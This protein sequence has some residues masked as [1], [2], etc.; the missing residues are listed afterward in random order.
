MAI[1]MNSF[2]RDLLQFEILPRLQF[3]EIFF[4]ASRV[5]RTWYECVHDS[6]FWTYLDL[7][8]LCQHHKDL[9][10]HSI[11]FTRFLYKYCHRLQV[12]IGF[13][14]LY[15]YLPDFHFNNLVALDIVVDHGDSTLWDI[16]ETQIPP[17][18][19]LWIRI[20]DS[21]HV[22]GKTLMPHRFTMRHLAL[23]HDTSNIIDTIGSLQLQSLMYVFKHAPL[24]SLR[25]NLLEFTK[26]T[27]RWYAIINELLPQLEIFWLEYS[28]LFSPELLGSL[29][30]FGSNLRV[31]YL[32][33]LEVPPIHVYAL[34]D[35]LGCQLP[36]LL[37]VVAPCLCLVHVKAFQKIIRFH[38]ARLQF[39][40]CN[41]GSY[42][43]DVVRYLFHSETLHG[44][45]LGP[46]DS[47]HHY[48]TTITLWEERRVIHRHWK[49][50]MLLKMNREPF[51][52]IE[53]DFDHRLYYDCF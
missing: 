10:M 21:T 19:L 8:D 52:R 39:M 7:N 20:L 43:D 9:L 13:R 51:V 5:C 47:D 3:G 25:I 53:C 48:I 38:Q 14:S 29:T 41:D 34:Y 42:G 30:S 17:L 44:I 50:R 46:D 35:L 12:V 26:D 27:F 31:L 37:I 11:S 6:R 23:G 1:Q 16:L 2:P 22:L 36:Q 33:A 32:S 40:G 18:K 15:F 49:F 28:V 4:C 45:G 24:R